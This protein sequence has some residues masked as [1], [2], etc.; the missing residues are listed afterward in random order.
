MTILEMSLSTTVLILAI[1]IIRALTL[2]K[3]PKKTFL[4]LWGVVICRLLVPFSIPSRFSFYTVMDMLKHMSAQKTAV[5][6][7]VGIPSTSHISNMP[8][9]GEHIEVGAS[10]YSVLPIHIVWLAG[11]CTFMLFFIVAYIKFHRE[12]T[13]SLPVENDFAARWLWEHPL[14][15]SVQIRQSDRIKS[16]MTYGVFR[17]VILL[18]K[19]TDWTDEVRLKVILT[20][21][22]V[23]I[24]RFD[25]L[26][27][28]LLT[29]AVCVHWF[30]P[31]VWV[32]YVL[33]N[34]D[35]ELSCDETVVRT[36]GGTIKSA[37]ALTL[38]GLEEK[39]SSLT[40]LV[41]NFSKNAI[42]ERI[43]SIMKMK[44]ISLIGIFLALALVIGTTTVFATS[45]MVTASMTEATPS[46]DATGTSLIFNDDTPTID[47]NKVT[48]GEVVLNTNPDDGAIFGRDVVGQYAF[49]IDGSVTLED[50]ADSKY[51]ENSGDA[52]MS[53][54]SGKE[55][56]IGKATWGKDEQITLSVKSERENE[57]E[58]GVRS[59][60]TGNV[61]SETV[62]TGTGTVTIPISV[63]GDYEIFVKNN[64]LSSANVSINYIVN[65][66]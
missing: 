30:N 28:L 39:K 18:P 64:S 7:L 65:V 43:V 3:L 51:L 2:Y 8:V 49:P 13:M 55:F 38:I 41:N 62:K 47:L 37:Y 36:F 16:P 11:M 25:T 17:P 4:V 46:Q 63:D 42:E 23:H 40:P 45:A 27:K 31:F 14:R 56:E 6:S 58:V 54:L 1:V 26:T 59:I 21:E 9:T 66:A 5:S 32:M 61:Y 52:W 53:I 48:D 12:F 22:F 29:A 33:A 60:S 50:V 35:I 20:H 15:R 57:L 44:K 34:R 19:K 10:T 24:R